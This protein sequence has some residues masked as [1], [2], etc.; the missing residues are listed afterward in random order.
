MDKTD[1]LTLAKQYA[2][3]VVKEMTPEKI[4][5]FGS[6][7]QGTARPESDID[8]AVIFS[9]F[10][11]DWFGT[12][13]RLS[14][15]SRRVSSLIEPILLDSETDASGFVEEILKTGELIYPQ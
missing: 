10:Q 3:A 11:G 1:A 7:A 8:V 15:L 13:T 4:V 2:A 6:Y 12:Y 14:G 9:G 5:L